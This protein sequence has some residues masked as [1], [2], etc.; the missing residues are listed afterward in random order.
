MP[1]Q[2]SFLPNLPPE[3]ILD[4]FSNLSNWLDRL[5]FA[6]SSKS[7]LSA[8][9]LL[10]GDKSVRFPA[11]YC[12]TSQRFLA[13]RKAIEVLAPSEQ[14][15][16]WCWRCWQYRPKDKPYWE[17]RIGLGMEQVEMWTLSSGCLA[18]ECPA[19]MGYWSDIFEGRRRKST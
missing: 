14:D 10:K 8:S 18:E 3:L 13:A 15:W 12:A 17:Q 6:V 9:T 11:D 19:C 5:S 2:T 1:I 7:L 4:I 16:G